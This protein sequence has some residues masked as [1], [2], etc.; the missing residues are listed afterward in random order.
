MSKVTA[1]EV[2][3]NNPERYSVFLDGEFA[4]GISDIDL[5]NLGIKTGIEIDDDFLSKI[6]ETVDYKKCLDAAVKAVSAKMY[7]KKEI[8]DKLA[9]KGFTDT[10]VKNAVD[11][12]EEY[13]YINDEAYA[14]VFAE[15]KGRKNGAAKIRYELISKG[16]MPEIADEILKDFDNYSDLKEMMKKK[17]NG[18]AIDRKEK[19]KL[20]RAFMSKGF[21]YDAVKKCLS[22]LGGEE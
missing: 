6:E 9:K 15:Y 4:F 22:E 13:G 2:Q 8:R 21:G 3:K 1:I 10:A 12:L 17:I 20:I 18:K 11:L 5:F 14:K 7:S 16:I 19:D